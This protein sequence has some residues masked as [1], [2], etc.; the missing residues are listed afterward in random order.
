MIIQNWNKLIAPDEPV[1]HL[2]D[3]VFGKRNNLEALAGMLNG[4]VNLVR[5]NHDR[6]SRT[7]FEANSITVLDG[8]LQVELEKQARPIFSHR[9][10][11]Y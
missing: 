11:N 5:G 3:F 10:E 2:G 1:L 8:P 9:L 7:G 6:L 4:K